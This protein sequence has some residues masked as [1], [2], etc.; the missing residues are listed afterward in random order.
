MSSTLPEL[1]HQSRFDEDRTDLRTSNEESKKTILDPSQPPQNFYGTDANPDYYNDAESQEHMLAGVAKVEALQAV[2]GPTSKWFLFG[3]IALSSYIY[4]LDGVTTWQYLSYAT[5]SVLEHS[6]SGTIS[7]ANAIIIA[8]GKPLMAKL[9]D[10]VGRAETFVIVT[11][12]YVIGYIVIATA[13]DV[14]QIAGGQVLYSFGYTGLQMLQQI[15]IADMTNLRW[16]GLVTGLVSAPFIINNFVSAEIAQ[17]ILPNWRWGYA[18]F[19]ILVPVALAPI[20]VTLFWAQWKA[21][22]VIPAKASPNARKP[23]SVVIRDAAL[24]MDLAGLILIAASLALILLPL[25][26]AP[27]AKGQWKNA[28]MIAMVTIGAVLFPL[29]LIYEWKVPKRPVV[30][31]RWLK[32]GPILGACL[33][34]FTDFVSFYLQYTYL[35]SYVYV[36]Q[37]WSYRDLT[38]FSATQSLALTIFGICGG[39]IMYFTRRFK[40]M[41]F[42]GLCVRLIGCGL[43]LKA[44]SATGNTAELVMCQILQGLGGG[45]AAIAIQVSAQASVAHYDVATVTAMVLLITEI[46]NSAGSAA[47]AEIW[48]SH[49]PAALAQHVPTTNATLLA[50]LYGSITQIATYPANDPIRLGA[51]AAYQSVMFKL[52]LG[53]T[54]V[55][56]FPPI[57]CIFFTKDIKLT[58][59]QNAVDGKDLAGNRTGEETAFSDDTTGG[60]EASRRV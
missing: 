46:G 5:S 33:I 28:S 2:W 11:I 19:A 27:A 3:G 17:G 16:R 44:R 32:R 21:K 7:T 35:Y 8:V 42:A 45:F 22:K 52:V 14:N 41:L 34:G 54:I 36:T 37:T 60:V 20:I 25:G 47:A 58:R 40:W 9:A 49:M 18:M 50:D 26:L 55:A 1:S 15:V 39:I 56:I 4:S 51:I 6:V 57:F 31:M 30:P 24:E 29:M 38:Y 12:L 23:W 48:S 53:A 10:V 59:S 43:M 13:N